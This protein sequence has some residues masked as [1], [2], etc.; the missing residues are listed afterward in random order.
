[1]EYKIIMAGFGGQG[2]MA[3][4]QLVTY[5]GMVEGK[6]V[7]WMPSYGPEMRGGSANC[8]VIVSE[9][10]VGAPTVNAYNVGVFMN[11]VAFDKFV[12]NAE[13]GATIF[14]NSSLVKSK[15]ER[16]DV[17]VYYVPVNDIAQESTGN[18]RTANMVMLGAVL[19]AMPIVDRNTVMDVFTKVFG[20]KR[21]KLKPINDEAMKAGA[22]S[23]SE[24]KQTV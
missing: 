20:E 14:V 23:V 4:G 3:M 22:K 9:S 7:S 21:E 1:M 5:A 6:N 15:V 19:E 10:P 11:Q 18:P 2:I 12:P 16:D 17:T 24:Q 13:E 8:S